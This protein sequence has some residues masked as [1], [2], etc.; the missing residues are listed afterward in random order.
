MPCLGPAVVYST[1][2]STAKDL[3]QAAAASWVAAKL[4]VTIT[5]SPLQGAD[6]GVIDVLIYMARV[7]RWHQARLDEL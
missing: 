5:Y 7:C 1:S 6:A 3:L 2:D 4:S